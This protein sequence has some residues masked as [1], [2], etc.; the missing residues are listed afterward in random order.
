MNGDWK[1]D[2]NT[3]YSA[4]AKADAAKIS[5][6]AAESPYEAFAEGFLAMDKGEKI[7]DSIAKIIGEAKIKAGAK[8][9]AKILDSDIIISGARITDIFSEKADDFA[10]M[11]YKEIRSFSTDTKRIAENLGK[12]ES[13]IKKIKAYLFEDNSLLDIDTGERR[14]FDPDCAITQSWQRLML[15]KDIK[16]HDKTLIEHELL[17]MKIKKENP[18]MEHWKAHELA[19]EKYD[20]PKEAMEY[21]GNLEKHKEK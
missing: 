11:Y 8:E 16:P 10:E 13:D 9:I 4:K 17:E 6:Y 5:K 1:Y 7:P 15:G 12:K 14:R 18:S 19:S 21:Y 2:I 3:R 20:Y